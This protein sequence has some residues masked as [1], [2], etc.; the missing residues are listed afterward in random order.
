MNLRTRHFAVAEHLDFVVNGLSRG[1]AVLDSLGWV[2]GVEVYEGYR[3]VGFGRRLMEMVL[4]LAKARGLRVVWL[5]VEQDNARARY[6]YES[7]GFEKRE[8]TERGVLMVRV[9]DRT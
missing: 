2:W 9:V 6:L 8:T 7:L 1:E 4:D 5:L 3:G